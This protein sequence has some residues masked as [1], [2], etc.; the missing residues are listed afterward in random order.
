MVFSLRG[1]PPSAVVARAH[2]GS[3]GT[4]NLSRCRCFPPLSFQQRKS[5]YPVW[6]LAYAKG[7]CV[8]TLKRTPTCSPGKQCLYATAGRFMDEYEEQTKSG[9]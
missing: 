9:K 6:L 3:E 8:E 1:P 4:E 2:P 5:I 7:R